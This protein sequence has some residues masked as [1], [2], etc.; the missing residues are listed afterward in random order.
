[1]RP[2]VLYAYKVFDGS[3]RKILVGLI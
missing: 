1:M 2:W 3:P